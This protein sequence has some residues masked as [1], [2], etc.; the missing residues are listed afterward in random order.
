[1]QRNFLRCWLIIK[2]PSK[3]ALFACVSDAVVTNDLVLQV[4]VKFLV[5]HTFSFPQMIPWICEEYPENDQY[6]S[7]SWPS[8][9]SKYIANKEIIP[10]TDDPHRLIG[11]SRKSL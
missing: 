7:Q 6:T 9:E 8:S 4:K 3:Y 1:M 10:Q 2:I 11:L 5:K